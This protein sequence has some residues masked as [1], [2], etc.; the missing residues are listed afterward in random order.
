VREWRAQLTM[1]W[2]EKANCSM[3][4]LWGVKRMKIAFKPL[5]RLPARRDTLHRDANSIANQT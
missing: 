1:G 5:R 4:R 2:R 3:R